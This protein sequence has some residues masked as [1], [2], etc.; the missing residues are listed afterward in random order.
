MA[1][2]KYR[3]FT[4]I[5]LLVVIAI[6]ALLLSIVLPSLGKAKSYAKR[7]VCCNNL[8]QQSLGTMVYSN[9]NNT[10]VPC[11]LAYQIT[12]SGSSANVTLRGPWFWD[13]SFW[14][15]DQLCEY[16]GFEKTDTEIFTC[17]ANKMR[18]PGDALWWQFTE[19]TTGPSPQPM[20]DEGSMT[21]ADKRWAYRASPYIYLFDKYVWEKERY[22]VYNPRSSYASSFNGITMDGRS[23]EEVVIRKMS[24]VKAASSH[25]MIMDT[26]ISEMG[27]WQWKFA[28]LHGGIWSKSEH[29]MTDDSNHLS[30]RTI[31]TSAG[32]GPMPEGMN[33]VFA[34]GHTE[35]RSPGSYDY[36]TNT[37]ENIRRQ[38]LRSHYFWW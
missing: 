28:D 20:I 16:A 13:V 27:N 4:L 30:K 8:R 29:T 38:Y 11:P 34:D 6:I 37:F 10:F 12:G 5:E 14:F 25:E 35:W 7:I 2:R 17:P 33:I 1:T 19:S 32:E 15:T 9:E 31:K 26:V 21:A 23:M 18:K 24:N 22:S 36:S 3:A